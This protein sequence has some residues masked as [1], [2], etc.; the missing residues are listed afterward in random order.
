MMNLSKG[1]AGKTM[2]ICLS[3]GYDTLRFIDSHR[4]PASRTDYIR[5][6]IQEWQ[7]E[8]EKI[9]GLQLSLLG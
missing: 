8:Q 6:I 1:Q 4:K 5:Y 9:D 3:L 7:N 2:T